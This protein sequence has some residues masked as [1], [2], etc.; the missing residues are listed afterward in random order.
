M[1]GLN[2]V[3]LGG[4][5]DNEQLRMGETHSHKQDSLGSVQLVVDGLVVA[6]VQSNRVNLGDNDVVSD[7]NHMKTNLELRNLL[8]SEIVGNLHI[9][10]QM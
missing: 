7:I 4:K 6:I 9:T 5:T 10:I 8:R 1:I 2:L 3:A